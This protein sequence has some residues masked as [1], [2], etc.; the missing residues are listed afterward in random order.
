MLDNC[1]HALNL[2]P[3]GAKKTKLQ[4]IQYLPTVPQEFHM[5]Q[6]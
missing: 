1:A 5:G 2:Q 3:F 6:N 4:L